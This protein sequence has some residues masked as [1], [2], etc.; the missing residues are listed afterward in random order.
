MPRQPANGAFYVLRLSA[1]RSGTSGP[2][3]GAPDPE[4]PTWTHEAGRLW[5]NVENKG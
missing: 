3:T 1:S 4:A 5:Q 2:G